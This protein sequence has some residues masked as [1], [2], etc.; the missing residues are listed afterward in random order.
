MLQSSK[1]GND[2][3]ATLDFESHKPTLQSQLTLTDDRVAMLQS[4][5]RGF[6]NLLVANFIQ[7]DTSTAD[8]K[9]SSVIWYKVTN[10]CRLKQDSQ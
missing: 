7:F 2:L 4:C 5:G 10:R 3:L 6:T 8:K 1:E 9:M